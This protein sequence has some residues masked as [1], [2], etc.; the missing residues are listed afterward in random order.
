MKQL[1]TEIPLQVIPAQNNVQYTYDAA[2]NRLSMKNDQGTIYYTYNV[3]NQLLSDGNTD[4]Q[5]D[6]NG[7]VIS[8]TS[9]G[10]TVQYTYNGANQLTLAEFEDESYT[11][12]SY[13]GLGRQ[14]YREEMSWKDYDGNKVASNNNKG[15][16]GKGEEKRNENANKNNNK[17]SNN[18]NLGN[19]GN[20]NGPFNNPGQGKKLGLYK[21]WLEENGQ[22][23]MDHI[24]HKKTTYLYEGLSNVLHKEY[25]ESG[26]PYAE[27]YQGPDNQTVSR[28]M[29]GMHGLSNPSHNPDLKTTGGL[30]YYQYDGI[31]NVS[32]VTDRY[33]DMIEEY[34]YDAFGGIYTGTTTP[35]N[36]NSFTG[37]SYDGKTG[38]VNMNARWYDPSIGRFMSEDTYPGNMMQTQSLNRYSYVMNNPVNYWDPTGHVAENLYP[39]GLFRNGYGIMNR[40]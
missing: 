12:Y 40:M 18:C 24:Y 33:G 26:S 36:F 14:I 27:Y 28:K 22:N 29:F 31:R 16:N 10:K 34:R 7:N 17:N 6:D 23:S 39:E 37:M 15:N 25:S 5:Y 30:L 2:G 8:K 13:D 20:G 38:L 11:S 4:Y 19:P 1:K 3:M 32:A 21:K 35:Y 9:E